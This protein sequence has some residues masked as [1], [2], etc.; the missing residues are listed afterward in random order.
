[1][2][3]AQSNMEER[4]RVE[5]IEIKGNERVT[6]GTVLAYLTVQVNMTLHWQH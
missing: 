3:L 1:M 5:S 2:T 4:F 6:D